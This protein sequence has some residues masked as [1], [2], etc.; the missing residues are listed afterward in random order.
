MR[1]TVARCPA[2]KPENCFFHPHADSRTYTIEVITPLFGGGVEVGVNDPVTLI[3]PSSIRGLLRFWWR[4]TLG[5]RGTATAT[6]GSL[7]GRLPNQAR[8]G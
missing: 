3:C 1:R 8:N 6:K 7:A 2:H 4:A 5:A